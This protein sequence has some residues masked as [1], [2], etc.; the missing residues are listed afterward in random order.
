MSRF[1]SKTRGPAFPA[2]IWK[3]CSIN[4]NR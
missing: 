4:L 1:P 3:R 2:R